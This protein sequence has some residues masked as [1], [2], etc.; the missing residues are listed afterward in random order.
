ML[1]TRT[2]PA[3]PTFDAL[4]QVRPHHLRSVQIERDFA[5]PR[6]TLHYVV[7][8]FIRSTFERLTDGF[9]PQSTRRAWRLTGDYGSGKSGF[10]LALARLG[11]GEEVLLPGAL[12]EFV[13]PVRLEPVLV[14]GEREPVGESVLRALRATAE[15]CYTRIPKPLAVALAAPAEPRNVMT[16]FDALQRSLVADHR[17]GGV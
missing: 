5:D 9:Q 17:A 12:Q 16:A 1:E 14:V 6:A 3:A 2:R 4:L 10:A 8:P 15:R 13:S 11:Q 7:T